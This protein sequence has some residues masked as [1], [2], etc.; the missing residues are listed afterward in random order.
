[1]EALILSHISRCPGPYLRQ[2]QKELA[3]PLGTLDYYLTK[4]L[5]RGEIYKL[6]RRSR[7]FPS[8]LD[9]LQAWAIYLL[10]EGPR[11]L[12]EAGRL[13]CGKRLCPEVRGLLLRSVESYECLRRDLVDNFII[14]MSML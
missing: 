12:E 13:K 2:L 3:A 8:Q 11:A 1:M 14:L 7:Y 4:L 6:G 5:R 10:R 9:E